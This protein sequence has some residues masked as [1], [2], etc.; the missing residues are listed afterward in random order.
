MM[1]GTF[2]V[3]AGPLAT[4]LDGDGKVN[5]VDVTIVARAFGSKLG[6][7]TY[8]VQADLDQN[9]VVSIIDVSKVAKDFGKT[10]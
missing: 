3:Q 8:N 2:I 5:I 6:D 10:A 1:F 4:D 7:A 9:G